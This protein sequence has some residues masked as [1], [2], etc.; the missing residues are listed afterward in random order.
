MA[1]GYKDYRRITVVED[2]E[3]KFAVHGRTKLYDDFEDTPLKWR[4]FANDEHS[5]GRTADAAYN[6][7]FGIEFCC[8]KTG[9]LLAQNQQFRQIP[10]G[11]RRTAELSLYWAMISA[12]DDSNFAFWIEH[13]ED[14]LLQGGGIRYHVSNALPLTGRWQY[15]STGVWHN[16][17]G[18]NRLALNNWHEIVVA[19][20]FI[21]G[22]YLYAR[23]NGVTFPIGGQLVGTAGT[24][25]DYDTV[26]LIVE[27]DAGANVC[28]RVDDV[29]SKEL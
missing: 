3:G 27:D 15:Y 17:T 26:R 10:F 9:A 6:G 14:G 25:N 22:L 29:L 7:S 11:E 12:S 8:R 24:V 18:N 20:D 28:M 19:C 23:S 16:L 4:T 13:S 21:T 5:E 1:R 2:P